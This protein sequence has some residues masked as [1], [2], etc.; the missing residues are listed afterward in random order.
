MAA[1]RHGR[2]HA[3]LRPHPCGHH[4]HG[5]RIPCLPDVAA[6]RIRPDRARHSGGHRRGDGVFRGDDR[7][8]PE[9]HQARDRLFDLFAARI[10]VRRRGSR[11]VPRSDVPP[12][13]AC[14]LQG[15]AVPW[16][17][18]GDH[19]DASRARHAPIRRLAPSNPVDILG[20]DDRHPRDHGSRNPADPFRLRGLPLERRDHRIDL[21]RRHGRRI[22]RILAA[23]GVGANDEFLLVAPD[24][25]DLLRRAS[26]RHACPRACA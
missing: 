18:V 2:P 26:R 23:G 20:D 15:D 13:H 14:V 24:V 7:T 12:V 19:C 1:R 11:R 17:R 22:V 10:H 3:G 21:R 8:R 6:V 5:G 4:G 9:R 25:H 16:R